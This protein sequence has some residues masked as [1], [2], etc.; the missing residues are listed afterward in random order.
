MVAVFLML[1]ATAPWM[2]SKIVDFSIYLFSN[3]P[4]FAK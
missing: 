2:F 3:I 1:V 4:Y